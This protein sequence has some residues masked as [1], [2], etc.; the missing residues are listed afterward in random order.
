MSL[1]PV[2]PGLLIKFLH[3]LADNDFLPL[4]FPKVDLSHDLLLI[5]RVQYCD[6]V[7]RLLPP[8]S[9]VALQ[10]G[11]HIWSAINVL[12]L[13]SLFQFLF[14]IKVFGHLRAD[15]GLLRGILKL[16]PLRLRGWGVLSLLMMLFVLLL[17]QPLPVSFPVNP[18]PPLTWRRWSP[19]LTQ[20]HL[21]KY[22]A[23]WLLSPN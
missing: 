3:F 6:G 10:E 4:L 7:L 21:T 13:L 8:W 18:P 11:R 20:S 15:P 16:G 9:T 19:P 1:I 5:L 23:A 12:S 22:A 17:V 2:L 14:F